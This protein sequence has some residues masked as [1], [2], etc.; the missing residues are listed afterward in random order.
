[1]WRFP[2]RMTCGR[3]IIWKCWPTQC[4][5]GGGACGEA[6]L[7][8]SAGEI[9][10]FSKFCLGFE[11]GSLTDF[12]K[13]NYFLFTRGVYQGASMMIHKSFVDYVFP[14]P[15]GIPFHDAWMFFLSLL[16]DKFYYTPEIITKYRWHDQNT[17]KISSEK[18]KLTGKLKAFFRKKEYHL[19]FYYL[20]AIRENPVYRQI[21]P[22]YRKEIDKA[23]SY[24]KY[25]KYFLYRLFHLGFFIRRFR[26]LSANK[27]KSYVIFKYLL[28]R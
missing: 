2:I 24:F 8:D 3:K 6:L 14:I 1:M 4:P 5:P 9:C 7:F 10:T 20:K 16:L 23:Y 21:R 26:Y 18:P 11:T 15:E 25:K 28:W 13:L 19:R 17:S 22:L 12:Q 27:N